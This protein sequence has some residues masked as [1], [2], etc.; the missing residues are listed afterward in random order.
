MHETRWQ[1]WPR[2]W[3]LALMACGCGEPATAPPRPGPQSPPPA[4]SSPPPK[5][6]VRAPGDDPTDPFPVP[7]GK[8][9]FKRVV[10]RRFHLSI[11]LPD[12]D[13]WR[14]L[15]GARSS[16]LAFEHAATRSLLLARVWQEDQAMDPVL[17]EER[18]RLLRELPARGEALAEDTIAVPAGYD[19]RVEVGFAPVEGAA[20]AGGA[21]RGYLLAFGAAARSCFAFV[22]STQSPASEAAASVVGE[23]LAVIQTVSL[24]GVE[25][26]GGAPE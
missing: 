6:S 1:R 5:P 25:L 9:R 8:P 17:C 18:A 23:R 22:Y 3:A 20:G 13:G 14:M 7:S 4:P 26:R 15:E 11:P 12:R 16:F 21:V 10:S 2:A 24:E 19:T